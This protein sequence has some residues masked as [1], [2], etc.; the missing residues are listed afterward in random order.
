MVILVPQIAAI[1]EDFSKEMNDFDH[2][3]SNIS[4]ATRL[5]QQTG[6]SLDAYFTLL[7]AARTKT[8]KATGIGNRMAYFF[9]VLRDLSGNE[10]E[11]GSFPQRRHRD[12][13]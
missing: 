9:E 7:Y 3:P 10:T 8:R 12:D 2:T 6:I 5:F 13:Q 11:L 1:M 4:Q